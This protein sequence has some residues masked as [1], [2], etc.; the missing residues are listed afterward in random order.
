MN[1]NEKLSND[2]GHRLSNS[3]VW[4]NYIVKYNL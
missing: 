4:D 2:L 1:K 3:K